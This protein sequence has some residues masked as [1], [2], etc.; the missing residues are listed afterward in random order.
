MHVHS[1]AFPCIQNS[2]IL[3]LSLSWIPVSLIWGNNMWSCKSVMIYSWN[4]SNNDLDHLLGQN[5]LCQ[6]IQSTIKAFMLIRYLKNI[7]TY[8]V[9]DVSV[10]SGK[11]TRMSSIISA[12]LILHGSNPNHFLIQTLINNCKRFV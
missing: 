4:L 3:C 5:E 8:E 2:S 1:C 10:Y 9:L 7:Y 6:D 12:N 11:C